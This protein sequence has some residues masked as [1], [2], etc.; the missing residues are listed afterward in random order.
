[1]KKV[2]MDI[3]YEYSILEPYQ[4]RNSYETIWELWFSYDYGDDG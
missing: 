4:K 3:D 1:L 2:G